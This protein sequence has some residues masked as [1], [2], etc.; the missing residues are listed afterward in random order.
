MV[1]SQAC[2]WFQNL[3]D[4]FRSQILQHFGSM[5]EREEN[6]Q[7]RC[8]YRRSHF[9][10]NPI[11]FTFPCVIFFDPIFRITSTFSRALIPTPCKDAS[12]KEGLRGRKGLYADFQRGE[13][14]QTE[15]WLPL[16]CGC[17]ATV[18]PSHQLP[19]LPLRNVWFFHLLETL[20]TS[21]FIPM[22]YAPLQVPL[23]CV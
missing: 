2:S 14:F 8:C 11:T 3:R 10:I 21:P 9:F 23:V 20:L 18:L 15:H 7:V 16:N 22:S 13:G 5:P 12:R 17:E 1:Y 6:L 19:L 4:R